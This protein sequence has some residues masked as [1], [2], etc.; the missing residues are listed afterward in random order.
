MLTTGT[1]E[2]AAAA[3]AGARARS[4]GGSGAAAVMV[5]IGTNKTFSLIVES[6]DATAGGGDV[7]GSEVTMGVV[8]RGSGTNASV[9]ETT[10]AAGTD[11]LDDGGDDD[12]DNN[13]DCLSMGRETAAGVGIDKGVADTN[14]PTFDRLPVCTVGHFLTPPARQSKVGNRRQIVVLK[15]VI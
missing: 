7:E 15:G 9:I 14:A 11:H 3:A 4:E 1:A 5:V 2:A 6:V 8:T 10:G 12:D 13:D